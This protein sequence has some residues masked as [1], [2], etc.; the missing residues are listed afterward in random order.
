MKHR[1][2]SQISLLFFVMGGFFI[3]V[4]VNTYITIEGNSDD[5]VV[6]NLAGRQRMLTQK[7][8]KEA[9]ALANGKISK[10]DLQNTAQLFDKTLNGLIYGNAELP[11]CENE[12]IVKRLNEVK[13][14][15]GSFYMMVKKL[16][17][18]PHNADAL[19]YLLDNNL[20]LLT[21]MNSAVKMFERDSKAKLTQLN[22]L[23]F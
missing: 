19:N 1:L 12:K 21:K 8:T 3:A 13:E 5:G 7:M 20:Q 22:F 16:E 17:N 4:M 10:E 23:R 15:W 6:I 14:L 2:R 18:D 11:P 9:I